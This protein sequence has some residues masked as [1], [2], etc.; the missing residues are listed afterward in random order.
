M[1]EIVSRVLSA[2]IIIV[3][4]LAVLGGTA[5]VILHLKG[6]AD[7]DSLLRVGRK[8]RRLAY[9]LLRTAFLPMQVMRDV[10]LP[11]DPSDHSKGFVTIEALVVTRGGIS[12]I[13]SVRVGGYV[14]NRPHDN[15]I[16][17]A[18]GR[19]TVIRNPYESNEYCVRAVRAMLRDSGIANVRVHNILASVYPTAQYN[20]RDDAIVPVE[21]LT[22]YVRDLTKVSY[23]SFRDIKRVIEAINKRRIQPYRPNQNG[24]QNNGNNNYGY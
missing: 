2:I 18:N 4:V 15:W 13:Q 17:Y 22:T 8:S 3:V 24:G 5:L 9:D 6:Q 23:V 20:F 10:I 12:V 16:F 7:A 21:Q 14:D 1:L 11:I 19:P